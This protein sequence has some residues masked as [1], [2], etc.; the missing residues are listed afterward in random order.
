MEKRDNVCRGGVGERDITPA[1]VHVKAM[2]HVWE[3]HRKLT[4]RSERE[5][6]SCVC[7]IWEVVKCEREEMEDI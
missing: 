4:K 3:S 1:C 6:S 7:W 5:C 2:R